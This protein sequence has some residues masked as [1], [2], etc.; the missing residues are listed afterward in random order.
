MFQP[1]PQEVESLATPL[2]II[3][4][5]HRAISM[6]SLS[7]H[8]D[9]KIP[10]NNYQSAGVHKANETKYFAHRTEALTAAGSSGSSDLMSQLTVYDSVS[11]T[12]SLGIQCPAFFH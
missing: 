3:Q 6:C 10:H 9:C 7:Q 5:L 4:F 11:L 2:I 12:I 8:L 1:C